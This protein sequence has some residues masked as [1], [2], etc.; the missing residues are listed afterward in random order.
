ML[1]S[2]FRD[3]EDYQACYGF[4][5]D[6]SRFLEGEARKGGRA[7]IGEGYLHLYGRVGPDNRRGSYERMRIDEI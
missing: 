4:R 5:R 6:P 1:A 7:G 2:W 3:F